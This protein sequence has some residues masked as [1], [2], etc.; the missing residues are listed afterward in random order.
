VLVDEVDREQGVA[1]AR[2]PGDAPEIDGRIMVEEGAG[3][4]AGDFVEVTVTGAG[5]Y[6][7]FARPA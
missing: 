2:G 4:A 7:L 5:T 6:D 1:I 3:L